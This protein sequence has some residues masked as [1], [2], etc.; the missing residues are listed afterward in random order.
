M[1]VVGSDLKKKKKKSS[2][3]KV[4]DQF[5]ERERDL[6]QSLNMKAWQEGSSEKHLKCLDSAFHAFMFMD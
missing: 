4:S 3:K 1:Y 6:R 2:K 5:R